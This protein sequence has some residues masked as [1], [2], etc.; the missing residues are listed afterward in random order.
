MGFS[1]DV[2]VP[3][4]TV[5]FQ[6]LISF[7]SPCVLPL[8]PLYVGYLS[9]GTAR[10]GENGRVFYDRKKVMVNTLFFVV[11]ISAAF[12]ILGL[13]VSALGTFLRGS[14]MLFVRIG[15]GLIILFGLYQLGIFG[16]SSLLG[17]ERRLPFKLDALAMSPV[18]ALLLGFTFSFAWTP[19]VGPA[20][21][22]VLIM[23]ASASTQM[24][25][26]V[27]IGVY[28]LGFVLPFLAVGLFTTSL[29]D[30]FKTHM[31]VVRYTVKA[32]G[33][34]LILMGVLMLTGKM[35]AVT[36]YL[37]RISQPVQKESV[38]G[39]E[40]AEEGAAGAEETA[41]QEETAETQEASAA[42]EVSEAAEE[43]ESAAQET[44]ETTAQ[45]TGER[46]KIPAPDFTLTDQF[47]N[48]HTL[49]DYRGK[50]I[51]LNFWATWCPPCRAEMPDIQALYENREEEGENALVVLG[52]AAPNY[53][54][55]TDAEGIAAFM[56]ENGYTYP[57]L[58]DEDGALTAAYGIY[59]Y[60]TTFMIDREG[61]V[62]GYVSG[63]LTME[64]MESIVRQ[65]MEGEMDSAG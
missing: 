65:T 25:A 10:R 47:G 2:S 52:V 57:V 3:V 21:A 23:A 45:E 59:S 28:T 42:E 11:G 32:G 27:L 48:T 14:Q 63:Q 60:P 13:G 17:R 16:P 39:E 12:F 31:Q 53:G 38:S 51:F 4:F 22:S 50:T 37:S 64:M 55:E 5:F 6:G 43:T 24:W 1:L 56:E 46:P 19:C 40:T 33:V 61:N 8:L 26:F 35:N 18:T 20:L 44:G 58:M 15:G 34:L 7:F 36:G 41:A 29:L 54:Q 9:G 30:F 62:F 49:E